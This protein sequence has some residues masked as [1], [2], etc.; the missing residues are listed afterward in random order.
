MS[1]ADELRA[2]Q[3]YA[4]RMRRASEKANAAKAAK[5]KK[6]TREDVTPAAAQSATEATEK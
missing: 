5:K 3:R 1:K 2:N 6:T 4:D